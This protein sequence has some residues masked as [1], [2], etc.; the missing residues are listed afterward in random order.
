METERRN[1]L[2]RYVACV[3]LLGASL[4][5]FPLLALGA[6][7]VNAPLPRIASNAL[8]FWPQYLLLPNGVIEIGTQSPHPATFA[9]YACAFFWLAAV[10]AYVGLTPRMRLAWVLAG[11]LPAAAVVTQLGLLVLRVLGFAVALDGP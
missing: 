11:L 4:L 3:A 9:S 10:G 2:Q 6:G 5:I 1:L 7:A 8:F